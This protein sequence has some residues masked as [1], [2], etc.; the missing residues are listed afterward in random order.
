MAGTRTSSEAAAEREQYEEPLVTGE[1]ELQARRSGESGLH[2]RALFV[3]K[4]AV[5]VAGQEFFDVHVSNSFSRPRPRWAQLLAVPS[6]TPRD[7]A[8]SR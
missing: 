2:P 3:R 6:G 1:L 4:L 8:V 5:D 7:S